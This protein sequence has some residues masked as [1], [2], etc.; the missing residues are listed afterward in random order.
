MREDRAK[1]KK[2]YAE[3]MAYVEA[4]KPTCCRCG[5]RTY[6]LYSIPGVGDVC[7]LC[8]G[9]V[10]ICLECGS[11]IDSHKGIGSLFC[12]ACSDKSLAEN[13]KRKKNFRK[14]LTFKG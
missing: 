10:R 7:P 8:Q 1:F 4:N 9:E 11:S 12:Q 13:K 6:E 2:D 14:G 3:H 5:Y